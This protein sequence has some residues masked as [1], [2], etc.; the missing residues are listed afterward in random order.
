MGT[1]MELQRV[2]QSHLPT[3]ATLQAPTLPTLE[4]SWAQDGMQSFIAVP[5]LKRRTPIGG[6]LV[7]FG[8]HTP[9]TDDDLEA[10][11]SLANHLALGISNVELYQEKKN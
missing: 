6:I 8:E 5:L 7:A 10:L 3:S 4:A 11:M 1:A 2:L 9:L